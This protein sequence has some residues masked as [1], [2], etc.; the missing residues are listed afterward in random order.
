MYFSEVLNR[1]SRV[2]SCE[3]PGVEN[4]FS[5]RTPAVAILKSPV[6]IGVGTGILA[7]ASVGACS[8][9]DPSVGTLKFSRA[10]PP[11]KTPLVE[12]RSLRLESRK[13]L[14]FSGESAA[15]RPP[16]VPASPLCEK[17]TSCLR[18][19]AVISYEVSS[20]LERQSHRPSDPWLKQPTSCQSI[21]TAS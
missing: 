4:E 15:L 10:L 12:T 5:A 8:L 3:V 20:D 9:A 17:S 2:I 18:L 16:E 11:L 19:S 6:A 1:A 21:I 13:F 14:I 7:D